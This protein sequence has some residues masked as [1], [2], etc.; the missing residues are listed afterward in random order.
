MSRATLLGIC[1]A[2]AVAWA[3]DEGSAE[4]IGGELG[5]DALLGVS[6]LVAAGAPVLAGRTD[7]LVVE[8]AENAK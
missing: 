8:P 6:E 2:I 4:V 1:F 5:D 3:M 7:E